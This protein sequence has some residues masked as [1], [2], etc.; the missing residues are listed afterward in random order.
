MDPC[1]QPGHRDLLG[2]RPEFASQERLPDR[3]I[4][5]PA[6]DS[7][8]PAPRRLILE[9]TGRRQHPEQPNPRRES[10]PVRDGQRREVEHRGCRV[11][12]VR[13]VADEDGRHGLVPVERIA[14]SQ[15]VD[16]PH[17]RAIRPEEVVVELF[18]PDPRRDLEAAGQAPRHGITLQDGHV[19][20]ALRQTKGDRQAKC[21]RTDQPVAHAASP[22]PQPSR[23][24]KSGQYYR[25]TPHGRWPR[26]TSRS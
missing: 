9:R 25:K 18:E 26:R 1:P 6:H 3:L 8:H 11:E 12:R 7:A 15:L 14:E 13:A 21:A 2:G 16:H 24:P 23:G 10:K 17:R 5:R 22:F 20:A 19:M 4:R